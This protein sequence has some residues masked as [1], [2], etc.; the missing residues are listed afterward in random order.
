MFQEDGEEGLCSAGI[1]D[2]LGGEPDGVVL[3]LRFYRGEV[4]FAIERFVARCFLARGVFEEEDDADGMQVLEGFG[5]ERDQFFEL[6]V[7]HTQAFDEE[8]EDSG[9]MKD[10]SCMKQ[11]WT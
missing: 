10:Q 1:L 7:F 3:V 4:E 11:S 8:G 5:V 9:E 6:D 2:G